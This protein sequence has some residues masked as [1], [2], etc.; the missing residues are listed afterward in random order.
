MKRINLR[1]PRTFRK[2]IVAGVLA[3][4]ALYGGLLSD[5]ATSIAEG[6]MALGAGLAAGAATYGAKN[7]DA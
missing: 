3:A 1:P 7:E 4:V 6:V 5:G 2:A